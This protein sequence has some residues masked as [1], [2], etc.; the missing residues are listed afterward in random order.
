MT[1]PF[2]MP[3]LPC[4]FFRFVGGIPFGSVKKALRSRSVKVE[5]GY[6]ADYSR[7]ITAT[8]L[9]SHHSGS[10][11]AA[12]SEPTSHQKSLAQPHHRQP[13]GDLVFV[14]CSSGSRISNIFE[15]QNSLFA[16]VPASHASEENRPVGSERLAVRWSRICRCRCLGLSGA[17]FP[18]PGASMAV[19]PL[20]MLAAVACCLVHHEFV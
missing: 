20:R 9:M 12:C 8:D 13:A 5:A 17:S 4:E 11:P 10:A 3:L 6:W 1:A 2:A 16:C 7:S 19:D 18:R 14:S 15:R